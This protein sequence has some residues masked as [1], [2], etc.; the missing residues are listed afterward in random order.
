MEDFD[1]PK[2]VRE[3]F[4]LLCGTGAPPQDFAGNV[5]PSPLFVIFDHDPGKRLCAEMQ[6]P[7]SAPFFADHFPR[8]PV[9]PAT[10][11]LDAQA[12]LAVRLAAEALHPDM[13]RLLRPTRVSNMKMRSFVHPGQALEIGAE[14]LK[15]NRASAEIALA[16]EIEGQRV[17]TCRLETGL[18]GTS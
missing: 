15:T 12:Q 9:L 11:L 14:I 5:A 6:V 18:W 1:D 16:A 2:V 13:G 17:C 10:L 8:K 3:R 4:D 7:R